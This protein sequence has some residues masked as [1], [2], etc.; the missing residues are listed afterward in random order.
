MI[1]PGQK[2]EKRKTKSKSTEG[3]D[4]GVNTY[5]AL[6]RPEFNPQYCQKEKKNSSCFPTVYNSFNSYIVNACYILRTGLGS[7]PYL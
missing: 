6:I 2:C 5:P 7:R 1:W 4:Q 3:M